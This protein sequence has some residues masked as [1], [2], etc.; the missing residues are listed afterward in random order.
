MKPTSGI[1]IEDL[2]P[3]DGPAAKRGDPVTI[4][5]SAFLNRGEAFQQ[6]LTTTVTISRSRLIAGLERGL[7]GMRPGARRRI[8]VSPHLAYR[9]TGVPGVIPPNAVLTYEVELLSIDSR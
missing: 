7:Q 3:G 9:D 5:Y 6:D 1:D 2:A 8:R 4:R